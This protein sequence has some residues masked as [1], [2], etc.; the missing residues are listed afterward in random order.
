MLKA[1]ATIPAEHE[2]GSALQYK[3]KG[4]VRQKTAIRNISRFSTQRPT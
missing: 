4:E 1:T 3:W 2:T